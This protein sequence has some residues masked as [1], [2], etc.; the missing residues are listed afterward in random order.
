[1]PRWV[2]APDLSAGMEGQMAWRWQRWDQTMEIV[3]IPRGYDRRP[4]ACGGVWF[5]PLLQPE[6][7]GVEPRERDNR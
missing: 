7:P 1:M 3:R 5:W 4:S 6:P 2:H